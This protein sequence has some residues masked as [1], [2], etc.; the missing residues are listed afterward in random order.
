[1]NVSTPVRVHRHASLAHTAAETEC[2]SRQGILGTHRIR[3][4]IGSG[5]GVV[6]LVASEYPVFPR[7]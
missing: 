4:A 2:L 5:S 3:D 7:N 6:T 1:M